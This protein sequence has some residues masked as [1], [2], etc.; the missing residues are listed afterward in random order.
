MKSEK[1][2]NEKTMKELNSEI[3]KLKTENKNFETKNEA[4]KKQN[5]SISEKETKILK[6]SQEFETSLLDS[7]KENE[8]LK[9]ELS[10]NHE[11]LSTQDEKY[12][13]KIREIS[14]SNENHRTQIIGQINMMEKQIAFHKN[15]AFQNN[16]LMEDLKIQLKATQSE[17]DQLKKELIQVTQMEQKATKEL[18]QKTQ[19][20]EFLSHENNSLKEKNHILNLE[21]DQI[22]Y[23]EEF[24]DVSKLNELE[25]ILKI[26][27]VIN[28]FDLS[29]PDGL[30]IRMMFLSDQ[31]NKSKQG[32]HCVVNIFNF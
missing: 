28:F 3:K 18:I 13:T 9:G 14:Q 31:M 7:K 32:H 12:Q 27:Q 5:Q 11:K 6:K 19:E 21:K 4:L 2:L 10:L 22:K 26:Y 8:I 1:S 16:K 30:D 24:V 17:L 20:V 15:Q 25:E 29:K 23:E